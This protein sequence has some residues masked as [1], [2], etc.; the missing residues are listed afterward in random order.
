M[1]DYHEVYPSFDPEKFSLPG[2]NVLG[3]LQPQ[4]FETARLAVTPK[5]S[6]CP[7]CGQHV[8]LYRRQ[9]YK[10]MAKCILWL[11]S[12][13]AGDWV[14]LKDGPVFRGGDNVKLLYWKLIVA[15]PDKESLYKPTN[16]AMAFIRN[17]FAIPKYCYV[18]NSMVMG[19]GEERIY[20]NDCLERDF[21][22]NE[23]GIPAS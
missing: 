13:Y 8:Q 20:I 2:E 22:M 11:C 7:C 17:E 21:D 16:I 15:H 9:V 6:R 18:Y 5:G 19:F 4:A 14:N 3:A 23:L 10:R 12:V 1:A